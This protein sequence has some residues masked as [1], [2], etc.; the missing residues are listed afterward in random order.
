MIAI[1]IV[2][3]NGWR[4]T[5]ECL[6]SLSRLEG[7]DWRII[8]VDNGSHDGSVKQLEDWGA[9][10]AAALHV[11][12]SSESVHALPR[13]GV[14]LIG[15]NDNLGFA[16]G[17]NVGIRHA[18]NDPAC[19]HVWLLNNDTVVEKSAG[20][21][22][23]H[24]IQSDDR[25]G[26]VGST[27]A[28]YHQPDRLQGVGFAYNIYAATG[29]QLG[30][31]RM[32][33]DLPAQMEVEAQMTYVIGASMMVSRAFLEAVGFM[34]ERYFLYFEE[35]DWAVRARGKYRLAWA[36][37]S[38][39]YHKEG[40]SIGT[41]TTSRPS[42]LSTFYMTRN[43]PVFYWTFFPALMPVAIAR[44]AFNMFR[45]VLRRDWAAWTAAARGLFSLTQK[46]PPERPPHTLFDWKR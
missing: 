43:L 1:V 4:D 19:T 36:P 40:G 22:L 8:V 6:D 2:N 5:I 28:Y 33:T 23:L 14:T 15:S 31:M 32:V 41:S 35:L 9:S 46:I 24:R 7:G 42:D 38:L 29:R 30:H 27:L 34:S 16:G 20:L 17:N 26:I 39:V 3:Y 11:L 25:V 44:L 18:L 13:A 37:A 21:A 45:F 12:D 10:T